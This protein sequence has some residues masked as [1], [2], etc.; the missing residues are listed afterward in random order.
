MT[1]SVL[2]DITFDEQDANLFLVDDARLR[3]DALKHSVLPRLRVLMNAAI[4]LIREIYGIEVLDDSIVSVFPNFRENRYNANELTHKYD[5]VFVGLGGQRKAKWPGFSRKDGK[6]V[7]ILPFRFAFM[8]TEGGL[9]TCLENG[10]LKGLDKKSFDSILQFHIDNENII[11]R[12]CFGARIRP[13]FYFS[14]DL[15]FFTTFQDHYQHRISNREIDNHFSGYPYRLPVLPVDISE[16]VE[17]FAVFFPIYDSYIQIAKG[18]PHRLHTLISRLNDWVGEHL[19][20][21]NEE[22]GERHSSMDEWAALA[23]LSAEQKIRVMPA[24]RWQVFQRDQ[25]KCVS[26]G[27]NSHNGAILH[28]DHIIPRSCGGLNS[29]SNYQTLCDLCNIGKSN[30]DAT[31]LRKKG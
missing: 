31:D 3:A 12:L 6:P 29:L 11:N 22:A 18:L 27:R 20:N 4:T 5:S 1:L 23:A 24:I 14:D 28:V 25:W 8:L 13:D 30:R 21:Q 7:Q 10:W 15:L 17:N 16:A 26:C 19:E 2:S 9:F